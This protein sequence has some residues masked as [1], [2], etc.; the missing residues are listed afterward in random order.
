MR[1]VT[2][3]VLKQMKALRKQGLTYEQIA[4]EL[5]ISTSTVATYI[6]GIPAGGVK[7]QQGVRKVAAKRKVAKKKVARI[8]V[9]HTTTKTTKVVVDTKPSKPKAPKPG[10]FKVGEFKVLEPLEPKVVEYGND[11]VFLWMLAAAAIAGIVY[12]AVTGQ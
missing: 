8:A 7:K 6:N 2:A 1:K 4:K 11:T 9:N 3:E 5:S 10:E 12:L